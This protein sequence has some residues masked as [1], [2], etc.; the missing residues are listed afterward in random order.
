MCIMDA[1]QS[2]AGD[3]ILDPEQQPVRN[4]QQTRIKSE[5]KALRLS[6]L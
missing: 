1:Q 5:V 2:D 6:I 3:S 4:F